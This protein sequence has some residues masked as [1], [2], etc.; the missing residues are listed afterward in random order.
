VLPKE[1]LMVFI[2]Y[3]W[4]FIFSLGIGILVA[5]GNSFFISIGKFIGVISFVLMISS[6]IFF[7]IISLPPIAQEALLYNPLVH[8][9]EMIHGFYLYGLDDRF[10][11]YRYMLLWTIIPFFIGLWLYIRLEKRIISL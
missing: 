5:V 11:D 4:L 9:M 1:P 6:A 2:A 7:P 8:F 3:L 10:V